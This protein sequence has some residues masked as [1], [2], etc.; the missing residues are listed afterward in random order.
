VPKVTWLLWCPNNRSGDIATTFPERSSSVTDGKDSETRS[1]G[2]RVLSVVVVIISMAATILVLISEGLDAAGAAALVMIPLFIL[3]LRLDSGRGQRIA[4]MTALIGV[5]ALI[6][7]LVIVRPS[8]RESQP[9]P[10]GT[11]S[12]TSTI[13]S[14]P[15]PTPSKTSLWMESTLISST[16]PVE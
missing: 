10:T 4:V 8:E 6:A 3:S 13:S 12:P 14:T 15:T 1:E 16:G 5:L 11:P 7:T 9:G 2:F